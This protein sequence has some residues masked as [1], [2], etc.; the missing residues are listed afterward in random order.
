MDIFNFFI[1]NSF[2]SILA[3]AGFLAF[4]KGIPYLIKKNE[5]RHEMA[6]KKL[7]EINKKLDDHVKQTRSDLERLEKE[8][9]SIKRHEN[10]NSKFQEEMLKEILKGMEKGN[11]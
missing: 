3:F 6:T 8:I 7:N 1:E 2:I 4:W 9:L 11:G 10:N 5:E